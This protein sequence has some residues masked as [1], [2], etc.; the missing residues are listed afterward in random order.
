[1][2]PLKLLILP[3]LAQL[4]GGGHLDVPPVYCEKALFGEFSRGF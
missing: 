3:K 1:L 4:D 2:I